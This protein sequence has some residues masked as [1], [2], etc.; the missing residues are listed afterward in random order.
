MG[1]III[2]HVVED[3]LVLLWSEFEAGEVELEEVLVGRDG[4]TI[5]GENEESIA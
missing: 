1:P 4:A 3:G 2:R 5:S